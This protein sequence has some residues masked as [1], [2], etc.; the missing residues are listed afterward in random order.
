[1]IIVNI[2]RNWPRVLQGELD[3]DT[4]T[5]QKWH[6]I[7]DKSLTEDGDVI[8]GVCQNT[9]VSAYDITGWTRDATGHVTFTGTLSMKWKSL[10]GG[11]N[12]G[13]RWVRGQARPIQVVRTD[14]VAAGTVPVNSAPSGDHRA[15]VQGY[16]LT[17]PTDGP[18]MLRVPTGKAVTVS[19]TP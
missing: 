3:A 2:N 17:V 7:S 12:P 9:V 18:A 16:V 5:L 1:M 15:I 14:S 6:L 4:A 8:V 19:L 13:K 11:P 10:V